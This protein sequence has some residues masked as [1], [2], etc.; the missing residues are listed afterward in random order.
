MSLRIAA[1]QIALLLAADLAENT[2]FL[3]ATLRTPSLSARLASRQHA[4]RFLRELLCVLLDVTCALVD[5]ALCTHALSVAVR[6]RTQLRD[7]SVPCARVLEHVVALLSLCHVPSTLCSCSPSRATRSRFT[8]RRLLLAL[9]ARSSPGLR[10]AR[11]LGCPPN[12]RRAHNLLRYN[13]VD[14]PAPRVASAIG[15]KR[16][17]YTRQLQQVHAVSERRNWRQSQ[18]ILQAVRPMQGMR[19]PALQAR[20]TRARAAGSGAIAFSQFCFLLKKKNSLL[21]TLFLSELVR[22]FTV[23]V[24]FLTDK[25][26]TLSYMHPLL[27]PVTC[28]CASH[29]TSP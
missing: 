25:V 24:F 27:V 1:I 21:R 5:F 28:P 17:G 6:L 23:L 29:H 4:S 19:S 13:L 20:H 3:G 10:C 7:F 15:C 8:F 16:Q 14:V 9:C 12:S 26:H 2:S 22:I 18:H 11:R